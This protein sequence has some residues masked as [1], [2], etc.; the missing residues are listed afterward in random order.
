MPSPEGYC[1]T[2]GCWGPNRGIIQRCVIDIKDRPLGACPEF[3]GR[4]DV[5]D[6]KW[7]SKSHCLSSE[8]KS[9]H[10]FLNSLW[11]EYL[12]LR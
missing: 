9:N 7:L 3:P 2:A 10:L 5:I 4:S 11:E 6:D 8:A 1:V 12:L